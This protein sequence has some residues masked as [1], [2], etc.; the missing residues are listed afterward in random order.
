MMAVLMVRPIDL[1]FVIL[2]NTEYNIRWNK[3]DE[4]CPDCGI[5]GEP[6][7]DDSES[8]YAQARNP[9]S[10]EG[11]MAAIMSGGAQR[12]DPD[13]DPKEDCCKVARERILN[14]SWGSPYEWGNGFEDWAE[15]KVKRNPHYKGSAY[16]LDHYDCEELRNYITL[17]IKLLLQQAKELEK[18]GHGENNGPRQMGENF[19]RIIDDWKRCEEQQTVSTDD[20][21]WQ[22][23]IE[24]GEPMS[25]IDLAFTVLK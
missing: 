15:E 18:E 5:A 3:D 8:P 10:D 12:I 13:F 16:P 7:Y 2:K 11:R 19:Q 9:T 22:D 23:T 4:E 14:E 1:A 24:A 6:P 21:N 25:S 20:K 17:E